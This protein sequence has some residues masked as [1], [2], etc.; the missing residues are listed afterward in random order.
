MASVH[1]G[2][3]CVSRVDADGCWA[4][5]WDAVPEQVTRGPIFLSSP[6]ALPKNPLNKSNCGAL[7]PCFV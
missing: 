4:S 3:Q 6:K 2:M 7:N 5:F 1:I